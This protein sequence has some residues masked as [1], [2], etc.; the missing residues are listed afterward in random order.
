MAKLE[1]TNMIE[2]EKTKK[3]CIDFYDD[4]K[5][6]MINILMS[7]VKSHTTKPF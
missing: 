3:S 2:I 6:V 5:N 4:I 7:C 1:M